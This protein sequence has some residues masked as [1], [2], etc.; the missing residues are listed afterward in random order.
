MI[1]LQER[2]GMS[3]PLKVGELQLPWTLT[4]TAN[5]EWFPKLQSQ[6][7]CCFSLSIIEDS[8]ASVNDH[9]GREYIIKQ[10]YCLW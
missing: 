2:K 8:G 1:I 10:G 4:S 3:G 7:M 9:W 5:G 6:N